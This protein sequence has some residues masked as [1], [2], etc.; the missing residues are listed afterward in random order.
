M[1]QEHEYERSR[2]KA[3][4]RR[5]IKTIITKCRYSIQSFSKATWK[6]SSYGAIF[7]TMLLIISMGFDFY[8]GLGRAVDIGIFIVIAIPGTWLA[9]KVGTIST[10]YIKKL[11]S[12]FLASIF[13]SGFAIIYTLDQ[14]RE[15]DHI[16]PLAYTLLGVGIV[17]GGLVGYPLTK[18]VR[19][20]VSFVLLTIGIIASGA[21]FYWLFT[22]GFEDYRSQ[23]AV[24][25]L[26]PVSSNPAGSG[27][28]SVQTFTYGSGTDK[29]RIA[30]GKQVDLTSQAVN[31]SALIGEWSKVREWFWG[32]K[33]TNVPLN[34]RV[35]MPEG[36]GEFPLVLIVHGNHKM[37][38]FS[39][40]GYAY[41]GELLASRGFITVSV[42]EN[43]LNSSWSGGVAGDING[44]AWIL[45]Q[46]LKQIESFNQK[47]DTPFY[48][49]V[50]MNEIALIGHSRGGQA[51]ILAAKF[52]NLERYPNNATMRFDFNYDI[53]TVVAIAP[54]DYQTLSDRKIE[55]D[56][57]N[58]LLLH[59]SYDSDL[60]EFEGDRQYNGIQLTGGDQAM[61]AALYI[62]RANHGQF[63]TTWGDNDTYFPFTLLLNKKPLLSGEEQRQIAKTYVSGFLEATLH[64]DESFK[65]M[66]E[67]YRYALEWLPDT[68]YINKY[69][70]PSYSIFADYEE[71]VDVTT[72]SSP[73]INVTAGSL[74]QWYEGELEYRRDKERAN[75]GVFL[76]WNPSYSKNGHYTLNLS[77]PLQD[78]YALKENSEL[79]FTAANLSE[80]EDQE[81]VDFSVTLSSNGETATV[82]L[83]DIMPLHPVLPVRH[84]KTVYFEKDRYGEPTEPVLQTFNIPMSYFMKDNPSID[85]KKID[86]LAFQFNQPS[87]GRIFIDQIGVNQTN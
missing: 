40:E 11:P 24:E 84:T 45:L 59:G 32:F 9:V 49:K 65:P 28:Y 13:V 79:T 73:F 12:L 31:A 67:D 39:D 51:A 86:A 29:Q 62:D 60:S 10:G 57:I 43:F 23:I 15:L 27:N 56:D 76:K 7:I 53:E 66:F 70:D 17:I 4:K 25:P 6:G 34:G 19:K 61:K 2:K 64:G 38:D 46:H 35:W 18:G 36:K 22:P 48:Q 52:N 21:F 14:Y 58:Y 3:H 42:D 75:H 85:L 77:K 78:P 50:D 63:N 82:L 37:E 33:D 83:S 68:T 55:M 47:K 81:S 5:L 87:K 30:F 16:L 1:D 80:A 74:L 44:R 72:T 41:L 69:E 71:D 26:S 8:S 54:T 20:P